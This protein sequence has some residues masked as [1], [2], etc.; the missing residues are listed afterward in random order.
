MFGVA[1]WLLFYCDFMN[2]ANKIKVVTA[3]VDKPLSF[4]SR[5]SLHLK[6]YEVVSSGIVHPSIF[7]FSSSAPRLAGG[8]LVRHSLSLELRRTRP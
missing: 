8:S 1:L 4:P 2:V 7:L 5:W 3:N 6:V